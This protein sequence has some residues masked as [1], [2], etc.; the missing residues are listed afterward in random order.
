[1]TSSTT[2]AAAPP[3]RERLSRARRTVRRAVLRRR[4]LLAAGLTGVAVAAGLVATSTPPPAAVTVTVVARDLPA[5]AVVGEGDVDVVD[6][7]PGSVPS[8]LVEDPVG[9][10][11]AGPVSSGEPVTEAGL[12]GPGMVAEDPGVQ[13]VP[14]RLPDAATVALLEVGDE[15]DLLAADPQAGTAEVVVSGV[16]VLA[17]PGSAEPADA[18]GLPGRLVVLGVPGPDVT[19][20][21]EATARS[22]VTY[23]WSAY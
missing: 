22:L 10:T 1:M 14:V 2:D 8:A 21:A 3:L 11:L 16:R 18:D 5:G 19:D 4:R 13:A 9:Q 17:V 23:A 20:L 7:A 15:V 12:V 6:F